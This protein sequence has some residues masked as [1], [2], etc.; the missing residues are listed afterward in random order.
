[1]RSFLY[2][3]LPRFFG[4]HCRADRS[5]FFRGQQFPICARCSGELVGMIVSAV[6]LP[7][8]MPPAWGAGLMLLPLILD[9]GVQALTR[10]ESR[11]L[12]RFVTGLLFA[13]GLITLFVRSSAY[14]YGLGQYY[15]QRYRV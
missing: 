6:L 1:M 14:V 13:V 5:F 8:W 7:L 9:G 4:C 11:N 10:Y 15:G 3:W 12:R 2:R